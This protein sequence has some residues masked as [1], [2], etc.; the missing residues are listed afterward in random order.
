ML[1]LFRKGINMRKLKVIVGC[2]FLLSSMS[3]FSSE[4]VTFMDVVNGATRCFVLAEFS[5]IFAKSENNLLN[6][7]YVNYLNSS[8]VLLKPERYDVIPTLFNKHTVAKR[9]L[10]LKDLIENGYNPS[11]Y[12]EMYDNSTCNRFE[13]ALNP[14]D[15]L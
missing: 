8:R 4:K 10:L 12:S 9:K 3:V 13:K 6:N 2:A 7:F 14:D 1:Y 15:F 11:F 5:G